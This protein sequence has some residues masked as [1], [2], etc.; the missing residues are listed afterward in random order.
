MSR[1]TATD[2]LKAE[3]FPDQSSWLGPMFRII[4]KFIQEVVA[5]INGGLTFSENIRGTEQEVSFKYASNA[6]SF[7]Q[8]IKWGFTEPPRSYHLVN[9]TE[10]GS[11][12]MVILQFNY[13]QDSEG[14]FVLIEDAV[15][16]TSGGG[17]TGL[18]S[19]SRYKFR[20]RVTP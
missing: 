15:K 17:S 7:P 11:P 9:G 18:T 2:K 13:K 20:I 19:G 8:R 5:S 16:L 1:V 10:N 3:D 12:I 14:T 4:N 6:V